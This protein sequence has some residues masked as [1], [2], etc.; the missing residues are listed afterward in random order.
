MGP[1][2]CNHVRAAGTAI[3]V[4]N[5][6]SK[7][8]K[9]NY[10]VLLSWNVLDVF[11]WKSSFKEMDLQSFS[12]LRSG[13]HLTT[14]DH[15]RPWLC[16]LTCGRHAIMY[17]VGCWLVSYPPR[18]ICGFTLKWIFFRSGSSTKYDLNWFSIDFN[19]FSIH[20]NWFQF[21]FNWFQLVSIYFQLIFNWFR[22]ISID[23][24][25]FPIDFDW[26]QY[27]SNW[28]S[29]DFDLLSI[30]FNWFQLTF[31]WHPIVIP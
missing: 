10:I 14:F 26:F 15:Q 31:N 20:F 2:I 9:N 18:T 3:Q 11:H 19:W 7:L 4:L 17:N 8:Q 6:N 1:E 30:D 28:C 5:K 22:L 21:I 23:F 29:F 13:G 27:T 25:W 12:M 24:N 16:L